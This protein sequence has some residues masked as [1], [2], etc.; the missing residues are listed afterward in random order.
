MAV[1]I[2]LNKTSG[3]TETV[4]FDWSDAT[5]DRF[6]AW[7]KASYPSDPDP[8][9]GIVPATTNQ[10]ACRRAARGWMQGTRDNIRRWEKQTALAAVTEPAAIEVL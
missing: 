4:T 9:T 10:Q 1:S 8:V 5:M 3:L 2:T 6:L 7:A